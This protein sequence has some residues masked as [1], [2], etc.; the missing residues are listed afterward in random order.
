[1][2]E[3]ETQYVKCCVCCSLM[4]NSKKTLVK[5]KQEETQYVKCNSWKPGKKGLKKIIS[6]SR[7]S[8]IHT[9]KHFTYK[10]EVTQDLTAI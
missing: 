10:C 2:K 1:M 9:I 5:M 4:N 6:Y 8:Y 7:I 3:E